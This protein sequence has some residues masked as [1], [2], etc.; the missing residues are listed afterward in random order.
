MPATTA[1][2]IEGLSNVQLKLRG[3]ARRMVLPEPA[4]EA[5]VKII[6]AGE[7]ELFAKLGG[8]FIRTGAL[9][10]SL[11]QSD[12]R[13]AIRRSHGEYIEVG[14]SIWYAHFQKKIGG[15]SGKPRGRKRVGKT[16]L[17]LKVSKVNR[18][19]VRQVVLDYLLAGAEE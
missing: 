7:E 14:S 17:V 13:G 18:A 16:S 2:Q 4:L 8:K 5:A 6:E 11:T 15:P 10:A 12:A 1:V 19:L 3:F 9:R